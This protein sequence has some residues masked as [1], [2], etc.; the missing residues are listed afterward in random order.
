[1]GSAFK[2]NI[3]EIVAIH[4]LLSSGETLASVRRRLGKPKPLLG[5][6]ARYFDAEVLSTIDMHMQSS[7]AGATTVESLPLRRVCRFE[8]SLRSSSTILRIKNAAW[9]GASLGRMIG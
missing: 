6:T 7:C 9:L 1:M 2:G 4:E 5:I 8:S 3:V